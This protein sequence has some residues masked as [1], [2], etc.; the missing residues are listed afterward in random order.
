MGGPK[1]TPLH[2]R[3]I[4]LQSSTGNNRVTSNRG[5]PNEQPT[6]SSTPAQPVFT[7]IELCG[8]WDHWSTDRLA[9][10]CRPGA[11]EAARRSAMRQQP[12]T[13]RLGLHS[14]TTPP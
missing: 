13:N 9:A 2:L 7:L 12:E 8:N 1:I 14:T 3:D 6:P 5:N 10:A 4:G 11:R